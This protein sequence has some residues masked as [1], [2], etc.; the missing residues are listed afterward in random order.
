[1]SCPTAGCTNIDMSTW[2]HSPCGYKMEINDKAEL[3]C[4]YHREPKCIYNWKFDCGRH[5]HNGQR[6]YREPDFKKLLSVIACAQKY[7]DAYD[8]DLWLQN[9][10]LHI[11]TQKPR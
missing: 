9:L 6:C 8:D 1:M 10:M 11:T 2:N 5:G 4:S 7:S 3:R